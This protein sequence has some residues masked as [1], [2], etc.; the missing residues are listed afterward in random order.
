M[1]LGAK[2]LVKS[3]TDLVTPEPV[4]NQLPSEPD[5]T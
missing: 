4:N 3:N 5:T 1:L 2:N